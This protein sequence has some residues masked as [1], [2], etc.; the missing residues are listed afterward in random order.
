MRILILAAGYGTRLY[1]LTLNLPKALIPIKGRP[2]I[3]FIIDNI[4]RLQKTF[5]IDEIVLV[6][7]NKFYKKFL[8]WRKTNR[9]NIKIVNDGSTSPKDR[10]GAIGDIY[11]VLRKCKKD[12]WL[13][14]GSDNFFDWDLSKFIKFSLNRR[15]YPSIGIYNLKDKAKAKHFGVITADSKMRIKSFIEKPKISK[16]AK[17]ATCI[18]FFHKESLSYLKKFL[19]ETDKPDVSGKYIEWL[20]KRTYVYGHIF[21]GKWIDVG[22]KDSL[23]ILGRLVSYDSC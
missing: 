1:P 3:D 18:Y 11:F 16:S 7:N 14:L 9:I 17:I 10:L 19:K 12:D 4:C 15:P 2:F 13:I 20:I 6:S 21:K 8:A 23:R 5:K 22:H